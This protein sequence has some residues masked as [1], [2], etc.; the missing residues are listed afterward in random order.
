MKVGFGI[1]GGI[2]SPCA[3]GSKPWI[4]IQLPRKL[5]IGVLGTNSLKG[6]KKKMGTVT[7]GRDYKEK[8]GAEP[9]SDSDDAFFFPQ[10]SI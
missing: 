9:K 1:R 6:K 4:L 2:N 5:C 3:L 7:L 10:N 8:R